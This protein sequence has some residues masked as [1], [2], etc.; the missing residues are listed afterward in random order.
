[1][2]AFALQCVED[3]LD[4]VSH[5][6]GRQCRHLDGLGQV[7]DGVVM[8]GICAVHQF[9][10]IGTGAMIGGASMVA[11]DV[12][13]FCMTHGNRAWIVGFNVVGLKRSGVPRD[14]ISALKDA[15]K[16]FFQSNLTLVEASA[17]AEAPAA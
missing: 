2:Q 17:Q 16:L 4:G 8:G 3:F 7:G 12:A 5:V 6:S 1:M 15:Y 11:Q 13:P 14:S 9:V 10:R